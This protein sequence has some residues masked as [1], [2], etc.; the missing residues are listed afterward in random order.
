MLVLCGIAVLIAGFALRINP[1]LVVTSAAFASAL[2]AGFG[3]VEIIGKIGRAFVDA[4]FMAV[5]WLALPMIGLLER[6]GLRE[7]ARS[8][9]QKLRRATVGRLLLGYLALRQLTAA[10]GLLS[11]GGAVQMVRPIVAPMAEGAAEKENEGPLSQDERDLVRAHAA[12]VDNI[13]AFFGEDVF[14]AVGSILL[15]RAVMEQ[16]GLAVAPLSVASW[17]IPTALFALLVHGSR[18]LWLDHRLKGLRR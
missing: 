8:M 6:S 7:Q 14:V 10:L 3:P 12:A 1:L 17:A 15:V 9:V 16:S 11:L 18:L 4:R 13:G 2:A 5:T